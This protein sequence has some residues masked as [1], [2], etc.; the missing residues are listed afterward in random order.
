VGKNRQSA[1]AQKMGEEIK[2]LYVHF[3][4]CRRKCSY[5]ALP[6]RAYVGE[7]ERFLYSEKIAKSISNGI[8]GTKALKTIYFG[9]G[10]PA[11][12][13]LKEV[14][15][16]LLPYIDGDTEFT[17]ELHPDDVTENLLSML[18][19]ANVNRIS[20]GVQSLD[21]ATLKAMG[22]EYTAKKAERAFAQ[23][24][25]YFDNAGIDLIVG[26][27]GDNLST[28]DY[29]KTLKNWGLKHC[30][31]YSLIVE[32]KSVLGKLWE[33]GKIKIPSDDEM[34]DKINS[35]SEMLSRIGLER[36]EIS[37]YAVPGF[38][39]RHNLATWK[40]ED[41]IGLG[42]GAAGRIGLY[43]TLNWLG[44]E[45]FEKH[46]ETYV[47]SKKDDE[48]E[49]RIFRLRTFLGLDVKDNPEWEKALKRF[50]TEGL[51]E[52]NS[53]STFRLTKRGMEVC[54]CILAELV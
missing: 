14:T 5:C 19:D 7:E 6:S 23:I 9:G 16:R 32:E 45:P 17:V 31:V 29:Y 28:D 44:E 42:E 21:D 50:E 27:P 41:Y 47:Q 38:E 39:C 13:N 12:G 30:S 49:R 37:N 51:V 40:G 43:R 10:T 11:L 4:F 2:N 33:T 1:G 20:M 54:D 3:P 48:T 8:L 26:Y 24:R 35:I 34:L 36:Y 52:E 46:K 25:K 15:T 18:K 22:R 53:N